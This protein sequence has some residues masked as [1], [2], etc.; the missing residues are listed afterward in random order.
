MPHK[1][2]P[3]GAPFSIAVLDL[4]L[5]L[6]LHASH[7][8]AEL[9]WRGILTVYYGLASHSGA[10]RLAREAGQGRIGHRSRQ[11]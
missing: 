8:Q 7:Q 9:F 6:C 5:M 1:P 4:L 10:R 11:C 2:Y 3:L